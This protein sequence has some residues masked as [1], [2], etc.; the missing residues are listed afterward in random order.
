MLKLAIQAFTLPVLNAPSYKA[1]ILLGGKRAPSSMMVTSMIE[2]TSESAWHLNMHG[3]V[4][5]KFRSFGGRVR[6]G[7]VRICEGVG[8]LN[9][10]PYQVCKDVTKEDGIGRNEG[11]E[12][13]IGCL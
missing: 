13:S 11:D 1:H 3:Q 7:W 8:T 12:Q 10:I 5:W 6:G 2:V 4:V 9:S